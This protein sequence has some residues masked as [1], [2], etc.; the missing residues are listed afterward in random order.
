MPI[1]AMTAHAMSGDRERCIEAGMDGYISKPISRQ[2]L[3]EAITGAIRA[4]DVT[5]DSSG[6]KKN[7]L[8]WTQPCKRDR[9]IAWD[10]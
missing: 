7:L 6:A 4:G 1:V 8:S 9:L 10:R 3:E 5:T 2:H